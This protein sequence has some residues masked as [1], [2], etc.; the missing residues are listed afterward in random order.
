MEIANTIQQVRTAVSDARKAGKS[1]GFVPTM[2]A[3]HAG[4]VSLIERAVAD[5]D[6]VVVSIFVNPTQFGPNEDFDKYPRDLDTDAEI[7]QKAG[8]NLIFAPSAGCDSLRLYLRACR[9]LKRLIVFWPG[10]WYTRSVNG[11]QPAIVQYG[12]EKC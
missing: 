9:E 2:G 7:C 5:C 8:A 12:G 1:I 3:L 10:L 6:F 11:R 4:H